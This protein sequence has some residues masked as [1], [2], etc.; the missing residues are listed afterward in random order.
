MDPILYFSRPRLSILCVS[1]AKDFRDSASTLHPNEQRTVETL[2]TVPIRSGSLTGFF[3]VSSKASAPAR[4]LPI[5]SPLLR[6]ADLLKRDSAA[7]KPGST[8][9]WIRILPRLHSMEPWRLCNPKIAS[10]GGRHESHRR[11]GAHRAVQKPIPCGLS[12]VVSSKLREGFT[13]NG[14]DL[15]HSLFP[16]GQDYGRHVHSAITKVLLEGGSL[17]LT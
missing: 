14:S 9:L 2:R 11:K 1:L 17:S 10:E 13:T 3:L 12:V 5:S 4:H 16:F 15:Y 6:I 7:T 8:H